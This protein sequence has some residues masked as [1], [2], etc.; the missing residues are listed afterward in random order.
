MARRPARM[1]PEARRWYMT[2]I[3]YLADRSPDAAARFMDMMRTAAHT[4]SEYPKIGVTGSIPGTRRL[5]VGPYMLTTWHR[6]GVTEIAA[7]RHGRQLDAYDVEET[8]G[9]AGG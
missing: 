2:E 7:I 8:E 1:S 5:A 6:G 3:R 9:D 4:L